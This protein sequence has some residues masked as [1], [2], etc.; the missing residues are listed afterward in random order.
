ME[1]SVFGSGYVGLVQ[2]A[3]LADVGH[4]V[5]CVD[6]DPQK[7]AQLQR[8]IPPIH[9]PGLSAMLE[10]NLKAKRLH[11][12]S[13]A[14]DAVAHGKLIF[15]A[16]GTPPNEDGSADLQ[17][18][19][20]VA[21]QIA[22]LMEQDCTLVIKSTV[23]VGTADKVRAEVGATLEIRGK[24]QL[25]AWVVSNPEFLKEGS[26]IADC[27]RPD[28]IIVG[29]QDAAAQAQMAELYAPFNRNHERTLYMDNR[30][31]ELVKYAA[32]AML[33]T[34]ISFMNELANLAERLGVDIEA[35][36]KGIGSDP[37]I[38][39]H[40][41]Y[42]GCGFGGSCFPKDL[43]ALIHTAEVN[44]LDPRL[45][46]T[47]V[48]I[49]EDQRQVLLRKIK[50]QFPEGLADKSI[51]IWGLA[52]KPN[53]DDMREAPS[54]YLMEAL[55]A[56]GARVRAFDPEAMTE[57][58]RIYGYRNDLELCATRDDTLQDADALVICTEWKTFRVV[59]LDELGRK[60]RTRVVIDGRNLFNPQHMANAGLHYFGIGIPHI[61]P[62]SAS[63]PA[64]Q[65]AH[66]MVPA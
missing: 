34:R 65:H 25:N 18:V 46:K 41:I 2:A 35:V 4:Q 63:Q 42:P 38:G 17:H 26:A 48:R 11:F 61:P 9:E 3:V 14:S 62:A 57:C 5:I 27:T 60:L 49:N 45:L 39:Y 15:I 28:R 23:P 37:R 50:E 21:R 24:T 19:L 31:A 44:G 64:P 12:T 58:R 30:S 59:D 52:F 29:T 13:Q 32:N 7:I 16:V 47:V 43:N 1:V 20:N 56:E 22:S 55:W 53:T 36:R 33:A 54:R 66:I 6:V 51:A 10:E 8:G 40:F